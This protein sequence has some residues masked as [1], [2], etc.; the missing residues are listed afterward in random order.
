MFRNL[1]SV[2]MIAILRKKFSPNL[3]K[4]MVVAGAWVVIVS[5]QRGGG[6]L[7]SYAGSNW[8]CFH[9][10]LCPCVYDYYPAGT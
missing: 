4:L 3:Y 7:N 10:Q 2:I 5:W 6:S 8:L 9:P 1:T